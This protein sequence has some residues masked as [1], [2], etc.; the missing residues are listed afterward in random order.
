L[1]GDSLPPLSLY[2]AGATRPAISNHTIISIKV[3]EAFDNLWKL[4]ISVQTAIR[5]V[6]LSILPP[7]ESPEPDHY[8]IACEKQRNRPCTGRIPPDYDMPVLGL[9]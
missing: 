2:A 1:S 6:E 5:I 4:R 9:L 3:T 8:V 7:V